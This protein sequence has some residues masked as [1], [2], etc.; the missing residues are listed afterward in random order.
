MYMCSEHIALS[1]VPVFNFSLSVR[2][3]S[4]C[5]DHLQFSF[6]RK[7]PTLARVEL[8]QVVQFP[9]PFCLRTP[10]SFNR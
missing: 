3:R 6:R 4:F 9:L 10:F 8:K 5:C 1:Y 2:N 7:L